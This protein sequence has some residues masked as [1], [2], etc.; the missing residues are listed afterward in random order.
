MAASPATLR[1]LKEVE[2]PTTPSNRASA[3]ATAR[4]WAPLTVEAKLT[5]EPASAVRVASAPRLTGPE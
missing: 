1:E 3:T 5:R 4:L 2:P